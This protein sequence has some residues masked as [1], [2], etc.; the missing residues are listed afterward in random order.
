MSKRFISVTL[1]VLLLGGTGAVSCEKRNETSALDA[2][3]KMFDEPSAEPASEDP[4]GDSS[5]DPS[6]QSGGKSD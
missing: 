6:E 1:L 5:A 4:S 2:W 3:E